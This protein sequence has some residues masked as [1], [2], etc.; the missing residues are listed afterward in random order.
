MS[1]T[2]RLLPVVLGTFAV[3]FTLVTGCQRERP[4]EPPASPGPHASEPPGTTSAQEPPAP[5]PAPATAPA[6]RPASKRPA[7]PPLPEPLPGEREDVSAFVGGALRAVIADLDGDGA[8]EIV[9]VDASEMRVVTPRGKVVAKA[10]IRAGIQEL[11]ASDLDG[12][13]RAEIYAGWG[14]TREHLATKLRLSVHRLAGGKLVEETV[15]EP[16]TTRNDV[17]AIVP[18]PDR[19]GVLFAYFDSKYMV[20]SVIARRAA[21]GWDREPV[22]TLR[23]ATSYAHGDVDGDGTPDL[24]VGRVYG[25]AQGSDGDAFVLAPDGTR[26]T[27]PTTRGLRSLAIADGD[28]DGRA[29][30]YF[31][32]GWH[33]SYAAQGQGLLSWSRHGA[34][35]FQTEVIEDTEGQYAI[36]DIVPASLG[37]QPAIIAVG[38]HYVRVFSHRG[39]RWQGLTI[40]GAVRDVAVGDLDGTPGDEILLVGERSEIVRLPAGAGQR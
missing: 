7:P 27:I 10:P 32:D 31:G 35:G 18:M 33:Q 39:G 36:E 1:S 26:A 37:G 17:A 12:D 34:G 30:V 6:P 15:I 13:G 22:A 29:E 8:R 28:G 19:K 23:T 16:T 3:T 11:V 4:A 20:T 40:G 14:T 2:S 24:V 5:A 9:L 38:N 21:Q 25:D